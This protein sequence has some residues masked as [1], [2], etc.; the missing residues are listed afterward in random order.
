MLPKKGRAKKKKLGCL[1]NQEKK[2]DGGTHGKMRGFL[3]ST[4][5]LIVS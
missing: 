5:E 2:Q 4:R 3:C 1:K